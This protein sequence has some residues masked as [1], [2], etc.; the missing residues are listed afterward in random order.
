M[1][2]KRAI[3]RAGRVIRRASL[4]ADIL[5]L[6]ICVVTP[7]LIIYHLGFT[8]SV[9]SVVAISG[10]Y[11]TLLIVIW[12]LVAFLY[13][14]GRSDDRGKERRQWLSLSAFSIFSFI[15]A[16]VFFERQGIVASDGFVG[17]M[18][19]N[20]V[21]MLTLLSV[22]VLE[23][24]KWVTS[25]LGKKTSPPMLLASSFLFLIAIGSLLLMLPRSSDGTLEYIDAL[26]LSTSAVCV[27]GLSPIDISETLT[28]TGQVVLLILIQIGGLGVM[29]I[30]S[31]FG[32]FFSSSRKFSGQMV[33]GD[34]LSTS[35]MNELLRTLASIVIVTLSIEGI[36]ALLL[37]GSV[38]ETGA[39]TP[40]E[41]IFFAIFHS[42]SAFCNGGFSTLSGNLADPVLAELNTVR[43]VIS[44]LLI[45]GGIGFPIF[46]NF[47]RLAG[48]KISNLAR[49]AWGVRPQI[50]PRIWKL[51]SYIVVRMTIF[52]LLFGWIAFMALEWNSSLSGMT[53]SE[54]LSHSFLMSATPRTAG[55]NSVD[56]ARM[57]PASLVLTMVFMWIGGA[58]QS[59]AGGVKVTTVYLAFRNIV[60]ALRGGEITARYRT[61]P[62]SSVQRAF[63]VILLWF[64]VLFISLFALTIL[65]SDLS[66]SALLFEV[67]SSLSTVGLSMG[68]TGELGVYSKAIIIVVMFIG[69]V[70]L[71]SVLLLF[72]RPHTTKG[73][74][75]KYPAEDIL[76]T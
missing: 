72:M 31:F 39:F 8:L 1:T 50:Q 13:M 9:E 27:T 36:G 5:L 68:I 26:F 60:A 64:T 65:E 30:T 17:V 33:V 6:V 11:R 24:S 22:S 15:V 38:M 71:L 53:L 47:L 44:A 16:I 76:I 70:G 49:R 28:T 35:K 3:K 23:I 56:I 2:P 59:T 62:S 29:T 58:P 20:V 4:I 12:L 18:T 57:V 46:A 54:K 67:I 37:Y 52:L 43:W 40:S 48:H 66:V 21:V 14:V 42:I 45:F 25:F 7:L 74:N 10:A 55:F 41:G 32:L 75:F 34:L 69:R 61:I 51:N 63:G 73:S 19:S